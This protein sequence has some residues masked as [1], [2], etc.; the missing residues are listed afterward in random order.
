MSMGYRQR[1][2][3]PDLGVGVGFRIPHYAKVLDENPPMD[4]FEVISEN[5]MGEGGKPLVN[6]DKLRARYPVVNHG[7][8]LSIGATTPLD[9]EYL[10]RLKTLVRRLNPPWCSDHLCWTGGH[11]ANLH[12][13]LPLPHTKAGI[14][15]VAERVRRVQD[16][17]QV[18]FALENVSSYLTYTES[19]MPEWAFLSEIAEKADCGILFDC[20]N[21]YVSAKNHDFDANDYVDAM[22]VDRIVQI[23]L[24]GHTDKGS[25]LLDTHSDHVKEDVWALYRRTLRRTG[26]ISTLVEWDEDIPEW[27]VLAAEAQMARVACA[28]AAGERAA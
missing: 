8:S 18:P 21:I 23:H 9:A 24:A 16:T 14:E 25:Y 1:H 4:W 28:E 27:D 20:N 11:R 26:R 12:D 7:V 10:A 6:L 19:T 22:P 5:F 15:H 3:I 17:L 13:L 2:A